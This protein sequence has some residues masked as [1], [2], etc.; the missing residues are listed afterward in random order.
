MNNFIDI[1]YI[2]L[3]FSTTLILYSARSTKGVLRLSS[4]ERSAISLPD[5]VKEILIGILLGDAH[6]NRRSPTSNSRLIYGQTTKHKEYFDLVYNI[7]K[8]LCV[9]N[10]KP[11][12][13]QSIDK[14]NNEKYYSFQFTTMQ[15]P[16]FNLY[17]EI[18][19]ILGKKIIPNN[20][21]ELLT[22]RG[23]AF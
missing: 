17:R 10:H 22:P 9:S 3:Y 8:P 4:A 15:L 23:L 18:F 16:C 12:F 5:E 19:Y 21:Y 1:N 7:F 20:I 13:N 6:I 11:Y 14:R 2:F